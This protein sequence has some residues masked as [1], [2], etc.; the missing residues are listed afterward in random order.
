MTNA[1][2]DYLAQNKKVLLIVGAAHVVYE[3]NGIIPELS[4]DKNYT[5]E[6]IK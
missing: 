5:I 1:A 2:K 4:K 6:R 3:E